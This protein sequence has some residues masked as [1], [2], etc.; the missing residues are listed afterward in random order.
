MHEIT[1][2]PAKQAD[3]PA[4]SAI[5]NHYVRHSVCTFAIDPPDRMYWDDWLNEHQGPCP[6]IVAERENKIVGWGTLSRWNSRCAYRRTVED[7]VYVADDCRGQGVGRALLGELL[8]LAEAQ[9]H[10]TVIAQIADHQPASEALHE[11]FGFRRV[12]CLEGVGFKFD[13][14]ID[15]VLYQKELTAEAQRTQRGESGY[16]PCVGSPS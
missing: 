4:V 3:L 2:R 1:L 6:A 9:D 11:S 14:W 15:V 8:R 12:G 13:R 16:S 10:R 7:S 5:Y